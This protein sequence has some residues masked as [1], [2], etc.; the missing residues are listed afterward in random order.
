MAQDKQVS[1]GKKGAKETVPGT[2]TSAGAETQIY[3]HT[4]IP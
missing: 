1:R 2:H 3:T 4:E